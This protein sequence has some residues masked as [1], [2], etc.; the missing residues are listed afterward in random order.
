MQVFTAIGVVT[1]V[2]LTVV[3]L[4]A[5]LSLMFNLD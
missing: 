2:V 1:V 3:G 5:V 4:F